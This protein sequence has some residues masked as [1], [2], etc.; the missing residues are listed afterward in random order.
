MSAPVRLRSDLA[1]Q[2][3]RAPAGPPSR[4]RGRSPSASPSADAIR[5][6]ALGNR[7]LARATGRRHPTSPAGAALLGA[8]PSLAMTSRAERP[9]LVGPR[10]VAISDPGVIRRCGATACAPATCDHRDEPIQVRRSATSSPPAVTPSIVRTGA[11]S[12]G[13]PLARATRSR[14]ETRLGHDLGHVRIHAGAEAGAAADA[15]HARAY[16]LGSD[17]VFAPGAFRPA[18]PA[19]DRLIGHELVHVLQNAQ[20][21][22]PSGRLSIGSDHAPAEEAA[23][24]FS[25]GIG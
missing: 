24:S 15:V 20:R 5:R 1:G 25:R 2:P 6:R 23:R 11:H 3:D 10:L 4:D 17:V 7:E 19:G 8:P 14:M 9:A 16:T 12:P 22:V 18:T 13:Q 21:P